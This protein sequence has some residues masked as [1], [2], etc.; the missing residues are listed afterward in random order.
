[1][2]FVEVTVY[3]KILIL[4][5]P[6]TEVRKPIVCSLA[7]DFDLIFS[8]GPAATSSMVHATTLVERG[9]LCNHPLRMNGLRR[10]K[11]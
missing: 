6:R 9:Q 2:V 7:R 8:V 3:S 11:T 1:M 4:R 10:T 5:F